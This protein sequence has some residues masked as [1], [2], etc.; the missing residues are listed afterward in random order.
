MWFSFSSFFFFFIGAS[1]HSAPSSA[2]EVS[3]GVAVEKLD[4]VKKWGINTYKVFCTLESVIFSSLFI[5]Y[6]TES[7]FRSRKNYPAY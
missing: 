7:V 2:E 4:S 3:R 6:D 1:N 5:K